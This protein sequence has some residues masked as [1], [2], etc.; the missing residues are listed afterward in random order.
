M[1]ESGGYLNKFKILGK[2]CV[3][4]YD[5]RTS[6]N[7]HA[8]L[9]T[10]N[11]VLI[12][13]IKRHNNVVALPFY[14]ILKYKQIEEQ[15]FIMKLCQK[16]DVK[17]CIASFAHYPKELRSKYDLLSIAR[18]LGMNTKNVKKSIS[19]LYKFITT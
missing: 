3:F 6:K 19:S 17:L 8:P 10:V 2:K 14:Q 18:S 12:K 16:Y 13:D 4:Y 1:Q 9:K 11:Q 5:Y 15:K 7:F